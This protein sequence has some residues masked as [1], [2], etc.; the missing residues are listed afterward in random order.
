[1]PWLEAAGPVEVAMEAAFFTVLSR[2]ITGSIIVEMAK[3]WANL[4]S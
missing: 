1:V 4:R 2:E 3:I